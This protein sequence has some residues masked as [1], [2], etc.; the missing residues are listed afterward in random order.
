[1]CQLP[2]DSHLAILSQT[3]SG[4]LDPESS[5]G[6]GDGGSSL[7]SGTFECWGSPADFGGFS[8][9][10]GPDGLSSAEL[11]WAATASTGR[12]VLAANFFRSETRSAEAAFVS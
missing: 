6:G 1:M 7:L 11:C 4:A 9:L 5:E 12:C 8:D 10:A 2:P 3:P